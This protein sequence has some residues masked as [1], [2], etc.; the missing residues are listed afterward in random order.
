MSLFSD[1]FGKKKEKEEVVFFAE[2]NRKMKE[3]TQKAQQNFNY[4]WR[5]LYWEYRRIIPAHDF[6]M[7]KVPFEQQTNE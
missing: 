4:F 6:S 2:Q 1:L 5:E 7:V 3:A